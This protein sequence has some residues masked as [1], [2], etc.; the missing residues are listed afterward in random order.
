MD[1][2][3]KPD[4]MALLEE[5]KEKLEKIGRVIALMQSGKSESEA[6]QIECLNKN[7]FRRFLRGDITLPATKK[8]Y[9]TIIRDDW[10]SW[11]DRF[12][13]DLCGEES[14]AAPNFDYL[15]TKIT[16]EV[17]TERQRKALYLRYQMDLSLR[18]MEQEMGLSAERARTIVNEALR[19]LRH[20]KNRYVLLYG[21][22]YEQ[23]LKEKKSAQL[24]YDQA[25]LEAIKNSV[26][27]KEEFAKVREETERLKEMAAKTTDSNY[28]A[29][30]ILD[31]I[32]IEEL[33]LSC[34]SFNA[35]WLNRSKLG[36]KRGD[37][38]STVGKL[39]NMSIKDLREIRNLGEKSI[40]EIVS[41]LEKNYGIQMRAV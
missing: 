5:G 33:N 1:T 10:I 41:V 34:R 35:L 29:L 7:W 14:Y 11:Q 25:R 19:I 32:S 20:P 23:L 30:G 38:I 2:R 36:G 6:C 28:D 3:N 22:E 27:K 4:N 26:K 16:S 24:T 40:E 21:E 17:L 12:I 39:A 15:F 31:L 37:A 13:T 8:N 9:P 18:D